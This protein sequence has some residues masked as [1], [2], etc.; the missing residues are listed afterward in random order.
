MVQKNSLKEKFKKYIK[1]NEDDNT[2]YQNFWDL[3]KALL[4]GKFIA[5]NAYN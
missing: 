2:I 4:K 3:V 5:L 1:L